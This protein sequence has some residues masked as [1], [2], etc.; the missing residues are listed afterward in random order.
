MTQGFQG[1]LHPKNVK[2]ILVKQEEKL[3]HEVDTV[4]KFT[5]LGDR[6]S[7]GR[8]CEAVVIARTSSGWLSLGSAVSCCIVGDFLQS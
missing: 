5:Y 3:C 8:G 7:A 6:V 4:M 2:G 1:I